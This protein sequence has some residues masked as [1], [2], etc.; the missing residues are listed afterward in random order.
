MPDKTVKWTETALRN[1]HNI[2]AYLDREF[3]RNEVE[4]FDRLLKAFEVNIKNF[5]KLYPRSKSRPDIRRAVLH[6]YTILFYSIQ[7][8]II[9]VLAIQDN[10]EEMRY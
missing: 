1:A 2:R 4:K 6:K 8:D 9:V 7:E 3:T 5:P 10:R